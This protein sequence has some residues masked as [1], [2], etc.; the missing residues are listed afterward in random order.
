MFLAEDESVGSKLFTALQQDVVSELET[1]FAGVPCGFT[2]APGRVNLIGEHIDYNDGFVLPMAIERYVVI[3][4]NRCEDPTRPFARIYSLDLDATIEIPLNAGPEPT[5]EGWGRYIEGVFSGFVARG[6]TIP[7]FDAVIGS[8]VPHGG[9]LSSSAALEVATATLLAEIT[10]DALTKLEKALLCQRAEHVFAGVPC[11]IMDQYSSVFGEANQLMLID[12]QS[13]DCELV[14]FDS[15]G[16]SVLITNSNVK[17]E[18]TGGEYAERR[19]QCDRA[20][21]KIGIASWR[22]VSWE[23]VAAKQSEL[24]DEEF[25]RARHVVTEIERTIKAADGF[26]NGRWE[27]VGTLM[28]ASHDSLRDDF[29]V[30][31]RELD[32]L[33]EI[34]IELGQEHGVIGS[35]MTGG[36]F[37]GSTVTLVEDAKVAD[38]IAAIQQ[39]YQEVTGLKCDCFAS[40]PALGA[41]VIQTQP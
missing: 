19:S 15:S 18:L 5:L 25:R 17:H 34:A 10:G 8:N 20:L 6:T 39:K 1:R 14:P 2:A 3:A 36:G 27:E 28:N 37:G 13:Q 35:R 26:R 40:H 33:V 29:E 16:V 32:V 30:S 7:P 23:D 22:D 4:A 9:G 31:C 21:A 38:V 11:G 12:C 24:T 41:H